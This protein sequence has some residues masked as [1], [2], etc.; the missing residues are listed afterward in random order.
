MLENFSL[1]HIVW[2][3][4]AV[5]LEIAANLFIKASKGFSR[6]WIGVAGLLSVTLSFVCLS[7]AIQ[8]LALSVAYAIWGG[9]GVVITALLG[10]TVF[11]Q[12]VKRIGWL[13]IFSI[14]CGIVLLKFS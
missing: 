6:R 3:A 7:Q 8:G 14:A 5:V 9:C 4:I 12:A 2:M 1:V 13:G 10:W 11:G